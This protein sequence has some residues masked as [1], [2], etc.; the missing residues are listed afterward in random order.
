MHTECGPMAQIALPEPF[1]LME[2]KSLAWCFANFLSLLPVHIALLKLNDGQTSHGPLVAETEATV[3]S[4]L[5]LSL[6]WRNDKSCIL[7][8]GR[9]FPRKGGTTLRLMGAP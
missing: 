3:L 6:C 4:P 2:T 8:H 7:L 1:R 9:T 5:A